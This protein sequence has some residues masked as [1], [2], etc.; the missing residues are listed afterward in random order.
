MLVSYLAPA[1]ILHADC[2]CL[3][4]G[5]Q[6][7]MR[8]PHAV[9]PNIPYVQVGLYRK[10]L[11]Q[12]SVAK[13]VVPAST[14]TG[15][16]SPLRPIPHGA[17]APAGT[18]HEHYLPSPSQAVVGPKAVQVYVGRQTMQAAHCH[19]H[20]DGVSSC[21]RPACQ[22]GVAGPHQ[23]AARAG[24]GPH[25]AQACALRHRAALR[26][27][28]QL[29]LHPPASAPPDQTFE[30]V[31]LYFRVWRAAH[32]PCADGPQAAVW[33]LF[34]LQH[35]GANGDAQHSQQMGG[36]RHLGS[37]KPCCATRPLPA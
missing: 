15:H 25:E 26:K 28:Q 11:L 7:L 23:E 14:H 33:R 16:I 29:A 32:T 24:G 35:T 34:L 6:P 3:A 22:G 5:H 2:G 19:V 12:F 36:G 20:G 18:V 21:Q 27:L 8:Q 17:A 37:V 1:I 4:A 10:P 9:A 30:T 31:A 13:L